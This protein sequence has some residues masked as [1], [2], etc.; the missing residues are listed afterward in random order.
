MIRY[1]IT[2]LLTS[3]LFFCGLNQVK[4]QDEARAQA[5]IDKAIAAH[6]GDAYDQLSVSFT[7]RKK[8]YTIKQNA[9]QFEY[10]RT[11]EDST[12]LVLDVLN[13]DG[14]VRSING[15]A[16]TLTEKDHRKFT[17]SLNS[18]CYFTLLPKGLNDPAVK[19]SMIGL[20]K[21]D[22][23]KYDVVHIS[24][25]EEGGGED[26]KDEF[27]YWINKKTSTIDFFAY[28]YLVNG[29][30]MRFRV[31]KDQ[32]EV[33]GVRFQNYVNYKYEGDDATIDSLPFF[34]VQ[35]KLTKLSEINNEDIKLINPGS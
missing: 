30:G 11:F 5:I 33:G 8:Q 26:H 25:N 31:A 22:G 10:T 18:V 15:S 1:S 6:G 19:K 14:F 13:N 7:F 2:L 27:V 28:S 9:G 12:G 20:N 24:F 21:I 4:S 17:N 16:I 32:M 3:V 29:G 34:Y 35:D 23:N